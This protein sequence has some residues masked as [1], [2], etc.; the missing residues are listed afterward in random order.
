MLVLDGCVQAAATPATNAAAARVFERLGIGLVAA[1]AAGCCGALSHHLPDRED[2]LRHMRRNIDAWWPHVENGA[3]AIVATASG[4]GV[5]L[6][7][8][9]HVLRFDSDYADKARRVSA[10]VRDAAEIVGG[11]D[12][13]RFDAPRARRRVAVHC[14]CTL[15]HGQKLPG[16]IESVLG[17]CGFELAATRDKHLCC[18][19][20]GAYSLLEP[21]MSARLRDAKLEALTVDTPDVIATGNVG[22]QLH[23]DAG[24]ATPVRHWIELLDEIASASRSARV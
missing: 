6:K 16:L 13:E 22:C 3:E 8:Y 21:A 17:R 12:L 24:T 5:M 11:E 9:G 20:A 19:S 14:P 1:P 7:E 10:L 15:Q 23:L 4:C 2:A 18:G